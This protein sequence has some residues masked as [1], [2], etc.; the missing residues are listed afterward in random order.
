M[1]EEHKIG[2]RAKTDEKFKKKLFDDGNNLADGTADALMASLDAKSNASLEAYIAAHDKAK[3]K[4]DP[5]FESARAFYKDNVDKPE[6]KAARDAFR[7]E[8]HDDAFAIA[9]D[10]LA[11]LVYGD[12]DER[13][14]IH[15]E[16]ARDYLRLKNENPEY[17][18]ESDE[19]KN[20]EEIAKQFDDFQRVVFEKLKE[21]GSL[22]PFEGVKD[23]DMFTLLKGSF[24]DAAN[25]SDEDKLTEDM[26][27][28][29]KENWK[30][31]KD[32][33]ASDT[34]DAYAIGMVKGEGASP[35]IRPARDKD[36]KKTPEDKDFEPSRPDNDEYEKVK[37]K[38][39]YSMK[40]KLKSGI[41]EL[42]DF[43]GIIQPFIDAAFINMVKPAF[44][45]F[46]TGT[47]YVEMLKQKVASVEDTKSVAGMLGDYGLITSTAPGV[48]PGT[49]MS[50]AEINANVPN[51]FGLRLKQRQNNLAGLLNAKFVAEYNKVPAEIMTNYGYLFEADGTLKK[52]D[53]G[54]DVA[55]PNEVSLFLMRDPATGVYS[56][57]P[58]YALNSSDNFFDTKGSQARQMYVVEKFI[59]EALAA[60][61]AK[62]NV[63]DKKNFKPEM[64]KTLSNLESAL[65]L[66]NLKGKDDFTDVFITKC[67]AKYADAWDDENKYSDTMVAVGSKKTIAEDAVN[68]TGDFIQYQINSAKYANDPTAGL[69]QQIVAGQGKGG[70]R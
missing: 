7:K 67:L 17:K 56:S 10:M 28:T 9:S 46:D 60:T 68:A 29:G 36:S 23:E 12:I 62:H 8:L 21:D 39:K 41:T 15:T 2:D 32:R 25:T 66:F 45:A 44:F 16:Q 49:K 33:F 50:E 24:F 11:D 61:R 64:A 52:N 37:K 18:P 1:A 70:G 57:G 43:L 35:P 51:G 27:A 65:G 63:G 6:D 55:L 34:K 40:E 53:D 19:E 14:R 13:L 38:F 26:D 5:I 59:Q 58:D 3:L 42:D 4:Y 47:E 48:S 31:L 69:L 20:D 30:R 54:T 22:K